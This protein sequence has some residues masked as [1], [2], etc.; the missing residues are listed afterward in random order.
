MAMS[1]HVKTS[2]VGLVPVP[3]GA[4]LV[5]TACLFIPSSHWG[6]TYA[7]GLLTAAAGTF[8]F[9]ARWGRSRRRPASL[10]VAILPVAAAPAFFLMAWVVCLAVSGNYPPL[11]L[12]WFAWPGLPWFPLAFWAALT[13]NEL[14]VPLTLAVTLVVS[15]AGFVVGYRRHPLPAPDPSPRGR[16]ALTG[17]LVGS[18]ALLGTAGGQLIAHQRYVNLPT[19]AETLETAAYTPWWPGNRLVVPPA[20]SLRFTTDFPRLDGATALYPVYAAAAQALYD[21]TG[22]LSEPR[23][24]AATYVP[25]F[26]TAGAYDRLI[27]G[28]ADVIFAAQPSAGQRAAA[29]AA[30]VELTLTPLGREAFV[31]FVNANN[32]VETLTTAQLRDIYTGTVTNWRDVGGTDETITA[33]QRPPDSG[34][35]TALLAQVMQGQ[36]LATPPHEQII[37]SMTGVI[38]QVATYRNVDSALGYSFRWYATG[39]TA[40]PGIKLLTVDG[41]SPTADHV[42]DESYPFIGQF[43]AVTAA[44]PSPAT[45]ALIAWLQ[46]AEGQ[47]LI[48]QTGYVG[49]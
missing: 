49:L 2:L 13:A 1:Y 30:G 20:P 22:L 34:S 15:L 6:P 42:R 9:W 47:A 4:S 29:R 38:D 33:F 5:M 18:L 44:K 36:P 8:G 28:E 17:V 31:F 19:V 35:Q 45:A 14:L 10:G 7:A 12:Q 41:V 43:Y 48:E 25:C 32:P 11:G 23:Q 3:L 37:G 46:G 26:G 27:A 24:V 21:T 39:M 40:N 16:R